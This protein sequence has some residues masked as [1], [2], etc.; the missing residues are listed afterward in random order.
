MTA[1]GEEVLREIVNKLVRVLA[2]YVN[3]L[4][5]TDLG[6]K[7]GARLADSIAKL[8]KR[9]KDFEAYLRPEE[10]DIVMQLS[11]LRKITV[12]SD[13]NIEAAV[14]YLRLALHELTR[15]EEF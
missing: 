5:E 14:E 11:K 2:T 9:I 1:T 6:S 7:E 4:E 3:A 10:A 12:K 15:G 8:L 13:R